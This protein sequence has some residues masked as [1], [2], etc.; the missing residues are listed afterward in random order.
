MNRRLTV[1]AL[2]CCIAMAG[3]VGAEP[4]RDNFAAEKMREKGY[5]PINLTSAQIL[6]M[7]GVVKSER[8]SRGNVEMYELHQEIP[9]LTDMY[10]PDPHSI[11]GVG[12]QMYFEVVS[13][14]VDGETMR[15][16]RAVPPEEIGRRKVAAGGITPEE[17]ADGL[18]VYSDALIGIGGV[19]RQEAPILGIFAGYGMGNVSE[20][21][22]A[23][24]AMRDVDTAKGITEL[25]GVWGEGPAAPGEPTTGAWQSG[26]AG[27]LASAA[28]DNSW[29]SPDPLTFLTGP[30]CSLKFGAAVLRATD[31][32]EEEKKA[33]IARAREETNDRI[34]LAG[35]EEVD[36]RPTFLLQMNDLGLS[37]TADDGSRYD[38]ARASVWIDKEYF[39]RRKMRL[40]G[41]MHAEGESRDF[42]LE[43]LDQDYRNV[44]GSQLYE[45]Y[46]T[47][48]RTGGMITP[49]QQ[50][51]M[52]EAMAQL[53][54]YE[55]QLASMP[56]S[57]RAMVERMMGDKIDQARS[58]ASGGAVE[59][60]IITT[61]IVINP[62]FS[63]APSLL[64]D[65]P[66]LVRTIQQG[67]TELGYDPGPVTG[68]MNQQTA[69][70]IVRFESA[71][72]MEV[73]GQATPAVAAAI[74]TAKQ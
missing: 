56:A 14:D 13:L 5:T 17:F 1:L 63:A 61:S 37:Q 47:V 24:M 10:P 3:T 54:D 48:L 66:D 40:E 60:E 64:D 51:E 67:L 46:R 44:P 31:L 35:E 69:V 26:P 33:A 30:A 4:P 12:V 9:G 59:F 20:I 62:D 39:V 16:T 50:R 22:D 23:P 53:E 73:T 38:F 11:P 70:A 29:T 19:I 74:R 43:S 21:D 41:T 27:K 15:F 25:C 42:F 8:L 68:E 45:P 34:R 32:T 49:E 55:Q 58:L 28:L 36:G 65:G 57:Q 18:D 6:E 72:G 71:R 52:Q 7:E 2:V